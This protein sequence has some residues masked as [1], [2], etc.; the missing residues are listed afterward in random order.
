MGLGGQHH[1]LVA[2]PP[3]KGPG[4][5]YVGSWVG[6]RAGLDGWG[7]P[8]SYGDRI[9]GP[10]ISQLVTIPTELPRKERPEYISG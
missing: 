7:I 8:Y 10:S 5:H 2:L 4:T 9:P 6:S 3:G 1:S